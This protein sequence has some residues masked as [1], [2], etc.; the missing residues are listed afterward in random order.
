MQH[1][2]K[3]RSGSHGVSPLSTATRRRLLV[4][5]LHRAEGGDVPAAEALIRLSMERASAVAAPARCPLAKE[6]PA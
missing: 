6:A 5:L 4:G 3:R 2:T 1:V